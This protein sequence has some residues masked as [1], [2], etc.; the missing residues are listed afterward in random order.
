MGNCCDLVINTILCKKSIN[1]RHGKLTKQI[2]NS[3]EITPIEKLVL[4]N[5][6]INVMRQMD[7]NT[8]KTT[9]LFNTLS[10]IITLGSILVSTLLSIDS[11]RTINYKSNTTDISNDIE[12][13]KHYIYWITLCISLIVT[14]A[15]A[16]IKLFSIDQ[17]YI[18]RHFRYNELRREGWLFFLLAGPYIKY[19][20]HSIAIKTFIFNIEKIKTNQIREEYAPESTSSKEE[21]SYETIET[22]INTN[23][24]IIV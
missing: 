18:I 24:T 16:F 1:S 5:R 10:I 22:N 20:T 11:S 12:L 8:K 7:Y 4:N 13:Q 14:I 21:I 9:F 23:S 15:N 3:L 19:K 2:I 6:Y 17:T